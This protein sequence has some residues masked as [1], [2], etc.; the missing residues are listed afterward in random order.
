MNGGSVAMCPRKPTAFGMHSPAAISPMC[1]SPANW[2][3]NVRFIKIL[4]REMDGFKK[5]QDDSLEKPGM[6]QQA[7]RQSG[8]GEGKRTPSPSPPQS[9]PPSGGRTL[10]R[11]PGA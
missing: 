6:E 5:R 7:Q 2:M 9:P 4:S 10:H 11:H 3:S 1:A 8:D